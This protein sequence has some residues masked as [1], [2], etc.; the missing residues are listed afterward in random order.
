MQESRVTG[1]GVIGGAVM[2]TWGKMDMLPFMN[3]VRTSESH[4]LSVMPESR[5]TCSGVIGGAV[6]DTWG[7]MDMLPLL[8]KLRTSESP[9]LS[10][11]VRENAKVST[12]TYYC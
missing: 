4:V 2:E 3:K 12:E 11:A 8:N 5:V 10:V 6:R 9:V 7:K 1:S